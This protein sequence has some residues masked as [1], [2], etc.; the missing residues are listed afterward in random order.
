VGSPTRAKLLWDDKNLYA[1]LQVTDPDVFSSYTKK[2]DPMW[3]EDVVELFIDANGDGRGYVELQVNPHNAQLD[4]WFQTTRQGG[5]DEAWS[6]E[7]VSAVVVNG[8]T[9]KRDDSDKGWDVEI[10]IP[11]A[12]V[13]GNDPAMVVS[14]PPKP[15]DVW[16]INVVRVEKKKDS[17]LTASAWAAITIQDFH[18]IDRLLPFTFGDDKGAVTAAVEM[19]PV[20][21]MPGEPG[22]ILE[23]PLPT[24][25]PRIKLPPPNTMPATPPAPK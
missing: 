15:G 17:G 6:S 19:T 13:K 1:F 10:A 16:K 24:A 14:L 2:D 8:T 11:L 25:I 12:A 7:M 5:G 4:S 23:T 22:K 18:A 21:P 3:K 20:T 9:D